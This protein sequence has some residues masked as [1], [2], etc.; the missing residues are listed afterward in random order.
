MMAR[1]TTAREV[2]GGAVLR[3][4]WVSPIFSPLKERTGRVASWEDTDRGFTEVARELG[5]KV[6]ENLPFCEEEE[7][8]IDDKKNERDVGV[9]EEAIFLMGKAQGSCGR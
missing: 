8:K 6:E 5:L 4:S 7:K 1:W 9:A 3:F 2:S